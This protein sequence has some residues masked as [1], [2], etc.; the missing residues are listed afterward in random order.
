MSINI[1]RMTNNV[2]DLIGWYAIGGYRIHD[3]QLAI[4]ESERDDFFE[5]EDCLTVKLNVWYEYC[6]MRIVSLK[7]NTTKMEKCKKG[8]GAVWCT[9]AFLK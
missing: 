5:D 1:E 4:R 3:F 8:R 7:N 2:G 9:L 6:Y